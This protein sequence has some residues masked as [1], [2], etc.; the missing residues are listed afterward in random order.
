M[1]RKQ[2]VQTVPVQSG[3]GT[4]EMY[5]AELAIGLL[6]CCDGLVAFS[7]RMRGGH[8]LLTGKLL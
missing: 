3:T 1:H 6:S 2:D 4:L 8:H 5:V 7:D